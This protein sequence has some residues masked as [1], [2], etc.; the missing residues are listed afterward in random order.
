MNL[1]L[2]KRQNKDII[3]VNLLGGTNMK[4][5]IA[6]LLAVVMMALALTACGGDQGESE[7]SSEIAG[8]GGISIGV[9][10][11]DFNDTFMMK[12]KEDISTY[13]ESIGVDADISDGG[14]EQSKQNDQVKEYTEKGVDGLIVN[15]VDVTA[16]ISIID[17][18][19][20][21]GKPVV[22]INR[23]PSADDIATYDNAY[24]VGANTEQA[25]T[26]MG[27]MVAEYWNAN[28]E[29]A[30]KNGDGRLQYVMLMGEPGHQDTVARTEYSV[31]AIQDAGITV[32]RLEEDTAQWNSDEAAGKMASWIAKHG[33][34]IE[35]VICNNDQMA[36]GAIKALSQN[37]YFG[38]GGEYV[39]VVSVDGTYE[40]LEAMESG[41]LY[42]TVL[43]DSENQSK[44]AVALIMAVTDGNMQ[45]LETLGYT[46]EG[47]TIRVPYV[48][49]TKENY[50][51][52]M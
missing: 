22:F 27:E 28:R 35:A 10:I 39:P 11:Y 3:Y 17:T 50:K 34:T 9:C 16:A 8:S 29:A 19:K 40:A 46:L 30:D 14:N 21:T 41:T 47:K 6:V 31:K 44:A 37:G 1:I 5:F 43:N 25:G 24:Y 13:S 33:N 48:K 26:L 49:I 12:V 20:P 42:G 7:T 52:Y 23:E 38:E 2:Q 4:K 18:V 15:P 51:E 45:R 32:E 36:L